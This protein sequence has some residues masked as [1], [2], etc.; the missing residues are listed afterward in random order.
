METGSSRQMRDG[1]SSRTDVSK[2]QHWTVSSSYNEHCKAV[3]PGDKI[4][5]AIRVWVPV[6]GFIVVLR[7]SFCC[8]HALIIPIVLCVFANKQRIILRF[9]SRRLRYL[10]SSAFKKRWPCFVVDVNVSGLVDVRPVMRDGQTERT[11]AL[12]GGFDVIHVDKLRM[13]K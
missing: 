13:R 3:D 4:D 11:N 5:C 2:S 6:G 8:R 9:A 10:I 12:G 1:D 7:I